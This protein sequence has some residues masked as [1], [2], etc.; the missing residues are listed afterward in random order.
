MS[1]QLVD[2][3]LT[4]TPITDLETLKTII[5]YSFQEKYRTGEL[6]DRYAEFP[7]L[8]DYFHTID[9][10]SRLID[11]ISTTPWKDDVEESIRHNLRCRDKGAL[12]SIIT[13]VMVQ[14]MGGAETMLMGSLLTQSD[15]KCKIM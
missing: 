10:P 6:I 3:A 4:M 11:L 2:N 12:T 8:F 9:D 14:K 7:I 1:K 13:L 15:N 5:D